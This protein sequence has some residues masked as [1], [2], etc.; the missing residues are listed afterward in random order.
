MKIFQLVPS[1]AFHRLSLPCFRGKVDK[2]VI[3]CLFW[4]AEVEDLLFTRLPPS[5]SIAY[6]P[7]ISGDGKQSN[8]LPMAPGCGERRY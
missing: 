5:P 8:F 4:S 1:V 2:I 3:H 6:H 7:L